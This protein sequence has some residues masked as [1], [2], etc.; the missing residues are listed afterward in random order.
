MVNEKYYKEIEARKGLFSFNFKELWVY[1]EL[2]YFFS[3]RDLKV[4]YKQT[5]IGVSWA[6][7]Q[8]LVTMVIFSVLFGQLAKIDSNGIPYP[9]FV[10][11]G[12]LFWNFY[13]SSLSAI[14]NSI[15]SSE[16]IIK[17]IYFPRLI[18]PISPLVTNTVNFLIA[19]AIYIILI[20]YYNYSITPLSILVFFIVYIMS[21]LSALGPGL[22]FAAVNVKFRDV[23]FALPFLIRT[24]LYLTPVIYPVSL[25]SGN[26]KYLLAINPLSSFIQLMRDVMFGT[27]QVDALMIAISIASTI[28]MLIGGLI[29]FN[30]NETKFADQI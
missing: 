12:L 8:P 14:S 13:S 19:T 6:V 25:F 15:S 20:F 1:R 7:L 30:R 9:V 3:W 23:R 28:V 22:F 21:V 11:T 2:L 26:Y 18:L 27:N 24:L 4:L 5:L 10:F 17:K 29:Y 16:G